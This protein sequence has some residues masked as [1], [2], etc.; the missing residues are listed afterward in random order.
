MRKPR[1]AQVD[2]AQCEF[3]LCLYI[4]YVSLDSTKSFNVASGPTFTFKIF[5]LCSNGSNLRV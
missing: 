3:S 1:Q 4:K 2:L 5:R